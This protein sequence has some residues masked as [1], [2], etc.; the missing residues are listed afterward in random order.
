MPSK[1]SWN[2]T[3]YFLFLS[4]APCVTFQ[5]VERRADAARRA[6]LAEI[7]AN[8]ER[9]TAESLASNCELI[10]ELNNNIAKVG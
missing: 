8:H 1:T 2:E 10:K 9:N 4:R 7:K 5:C 6:I 3:G